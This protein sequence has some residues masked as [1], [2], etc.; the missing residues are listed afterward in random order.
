M[1]LLLYARY[2]YEADVISEL[3]W[4]SLFIA[5]FVVISA[6]ALGLYCSYRVKSSEFNQRANKVCPRPI[7]PVD[8]SAF[9]CLFIFESVLA[10]QCGWSDPDHLQCNHG[11][12]RRRRQQ[13]VVQALGFLCG[14]IHSMCFGLGDCTLHWLDVQSQKAG[15]SVSTGS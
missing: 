11:K 13:D 2:S 9:F 4:P 1:N 10:R 5:V 7:S 3:D 6:V 8:C 12:Q 14:C 15:K